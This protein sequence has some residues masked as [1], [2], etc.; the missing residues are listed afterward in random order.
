VKEYLSHLKA[1]D[2]RTG[3]ILVLSA[4]LPVLYVYNGI[5]SFYLGTVAPAL[6]LDGNPMADMYA[7]WYR[8]GSVFL[9]FC[10]V[11]IIAG[12]A[13]LKEGP[14][15]FGFAVGDWKTGL[16]VLAIALVV[17]APF[18]YMSAGQADFQAEYPLS[19]L[20]VRE[21]GRFAFYEFTYVFYYIGWET[22]F[23]GYML[24]GLKDRYGSFGAIMF[25]AFPSILVHIGK[26]VGEIW[27]AVAAAFL[28][29][30]FAL[31]TRSVLY[32]F[33]FHYA[34]GVLMDVFCAFRGGLLGG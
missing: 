8:F 26:P 2:R 10:L 19:K 17:A 15:R 16:K 6:G 29:G 9:L 7:Q 20:A 23:R 34:I 21:P 32:V 11:P 25:Q 24:F 13:V 30:A 28:L 14:G 1:P 4:I 33:L 31:R 3:L 27:G 18:L 12:K 5:P 22:L